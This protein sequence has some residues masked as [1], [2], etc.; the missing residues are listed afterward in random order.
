MT[1]KE[2]FKTPKQPLLNIYCTAGF[3]HKESLTEILPALE[4][5]GA[6][7]VEIGIPYSDP[8]SDG[9]TIQK[10]NAIAL[11]NGITMELIFEQLEKCSIN[12]PTIMMGYFNTAFQF[13]LERFCKRCQDCGVSG[14]ILP[15]LPIHDYLKNYKSIFAAHKL[16][17]IFLI[18]P[19]SSEERIRYIDQHSDAFIYAVSSSST[20]GKQTGITGAE[21]YL[22]RLR[23]MNI[24]NPLMVGFNISNHH[25][26]NFVA[27]YARGG[28]IGSSFIRHLM[29]GSDPARDTHSFVHSILHNTQR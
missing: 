27:R 24:K 28:I 12:I 9:P 7:M 20:T 1:I 17:N 13:G 8:L 16:S 15:D 10:S 21:S 23:K 6:D 22:E 4:A 3:P 5:A 18:T 14:I 29:A 11:E 26:F 2:I 25:D 19:E